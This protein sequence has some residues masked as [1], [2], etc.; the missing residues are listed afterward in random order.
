MK[1]LS[2]P[3]CCGKLHLLRTPCRKRH[4]TTV[5]RPCDFFLAQGRETSNLNQ[6]SGP[7]CCGKLHLLRTPCRKRHETAVPRPCDFFWRKG[8]KPQTSTSRVHLERS[9]APLLRQ[10][11]SKVLRLFFNERQTH[12]TSALFLN[13]I[14]DLRL[15]IQAF[16]PCNG[17]VP[18]ARYRARSNR[19]LMPADGTAESN[20]AYS[21]WFRC[22]T[23]TRT[24]KTSRPT[25]A[26][27]ILSTVVLRREHRLDF[28]QTTRIF[29][30]HKEMLYLVVW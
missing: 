7:T 23:A 9:S 30:F 14:T 19:C 21:L 18:I 3:T 4:E 17:I 15:P 24:E 8:G 29:P 22:G 25:E 10:T 28:H 16:G 26:S 11:L 5:P 2:G 20:S 6:P 27:Q 13:L 12:S 1:T